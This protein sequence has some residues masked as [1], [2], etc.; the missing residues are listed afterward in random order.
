MRFTS[1]ASWGVA[2]LAMSVG[3]PSA[4]PTC[5][6]PTGREVRAA[7]ADDFPRSLLAVL[8]PLPVLA[9]LVAVVH[10]TGRKTER[11]E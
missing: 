3:A 4:C 5:D 11:E 6:S 7:I 1:L 8:A 2:A 10:G 9:T